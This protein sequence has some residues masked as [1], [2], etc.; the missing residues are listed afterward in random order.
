VTQV[1]G[2]FAVAARS[3]I[4]HAAS[5]WHIFPVSLTWF[6]TVIDCHDPEA[7]AAFWCQVLGYLVVFRNEREVDIAPGPSSFPGLAFLLAPGRKEVK[8]RLHSGN[9]VPDV[10][11]RT[12]HLVL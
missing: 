8:N 1:N 3:I 2:A 12:G 4:R 11:R 7:L 5:R 10:I 9:V 6:G